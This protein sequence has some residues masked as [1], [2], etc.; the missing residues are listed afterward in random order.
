MKAQLQTCFYL[1]SFK[2]I[3]RGRDL[4][5]RFCEYTNRR[6]KLVK[7]TERQK[8]LETCKNS[9]LIPDF[10]KFRIPKNG[11]FSNSAVF[12]FQFKLLKKEIFD[13]K[14]AIKNLNS[15]IFERRQAITN[16]IHFDDNNSHLLRYIAN[17]SK[18]LSEKERE[19]IRQRLNY[20]LEKCSCRQDTPLFKVNGTIK[21]LGEITSAP[22]YV[23]ETLKLDPRNPILETFE[24][25]CKNRLK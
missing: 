6:L 25:I 5:K 2:N 19:K 7:V 4:L 20:K 17:H 10:L 24:I 14:E 18:I 9:K 3:L 16:K 1:T 11:K 21:F 22:D 8:M 12:E 15:T 23:I 13:C